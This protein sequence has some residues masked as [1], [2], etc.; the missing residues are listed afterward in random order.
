MSSNLVY[1]AFPQSS[2]H[3]FE[4]PCITFHFFNKQIILSFIQEGNLEEELLLLE[5]K[6]RRNDA[7]MEEEEFWQNELQIELES[8]RQLRQQLSELQGGVRDCEAKL[9]EYLARIQVSLPSQ[10]SYLIPLGCCFI[11]LY[12][13]GFPSMRNR[14]SI[15]FL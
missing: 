8:E 1:T 5:Q 9:S 2:R 12:R 3:V 11:A 6:V 10:R 13:K 14:V 7:E 4:H 15:G